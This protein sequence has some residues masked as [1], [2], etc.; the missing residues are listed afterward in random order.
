MI[1]NAEYCP[2]CG[3]LTESGY[4]NSGLAYFPLAKFRKN[5]MIA[6]SL[7]G[8]T[9]WSRLMS[10]RITYFPANLCRACGW[11]TIDTN[12]VVAHVDV[13]RLAREG[14]GAT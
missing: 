8:T 6:E 9:W 7:S 3:A 12:V 13:Q 14:D 2:R 1:E 11:L 5:V 10:P 4:A